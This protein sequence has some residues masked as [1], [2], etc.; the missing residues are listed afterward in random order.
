MIRKYL[1]SSLLVLLPLCLASWSAG[2]DVDE[3]ACPQILE[4][5]C[6]RCHT[7][8]R[9]CRKLGASEADWQATIAKMAKRG[10]L[11]QETQDLALNCLVKASEPGKFVCGK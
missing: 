6:T 7:S 4:S 9:I 8:E 5:N 11:S 1:V 3:A 10:K 2:Q